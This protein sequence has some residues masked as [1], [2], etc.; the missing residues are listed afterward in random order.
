MD[1]NA[2]DW[3][4]V[5]NYGLKVLGYAVGTIIVTFASILFAKLKGKIKDSRIIAYVKEVVRAAEQIYPNMG[6]KMGPEKYE[7]V[8]KMVL[9]KFP[10]ITDNGYLKSLIEG[11]VYSLSEAND[12]VIADKKVEVQEVKEE[13]K[14][15]NILSSF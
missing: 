13:K 3:N 6:K 9:A 12:K 8:S 2:I 1:F 5:L 14:E 15:E 4:L 11:A 10:T 7:Y